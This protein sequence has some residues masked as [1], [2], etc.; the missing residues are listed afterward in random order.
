MRGAG[1]ILL[2]LA[3]TACGWT[4]A[5]EQVLIEFFERAELH[6][7]TR[8]A[9]VATVTF[10]PKVEGV[11]ERFEIVERGPEQ[12]LEGGGAR[13]EL[14]LAAIVRSPGGVEGERELRVTLDRGEGGW[15]VTRVR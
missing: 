4:P 14:R 2:L 12:P 1:A 3:A 8:L 9:A 11:V 10:N 7:T 15:M 5:D 13:R 6:D